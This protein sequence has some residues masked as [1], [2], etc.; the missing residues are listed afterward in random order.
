MS[1][2]LGGEKRFR[3]QGEGDLGERMSRALAESFR[4]GSPATVIIGSDCPG[5]SPESLARA[6]DSLSH[7]R[8]VIGPAR[9]G[10]YY[11]IGLTGSYPRNFSRS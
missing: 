3:I 2:W 9:D 1:H 10:G 11:L 8:V 5:L 7:S 6:F 4:E